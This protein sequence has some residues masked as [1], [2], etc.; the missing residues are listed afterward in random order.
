MIRGIKCGLILAALVV[1]VGGCIDGSDGE[2]ESHADPSEDPQTT[3]YEHIR[4]LLSESCTS[5]HR[6]GGLA[7]FSL[8]SYEQAQRW[9]GPMATAVAARTMP[10]YFADDSGAC[11]S[12]RNSFW[13]SEAQIDVFTAWVDD[14]TPPGDPSIP[15]PP[16][17]EVLA[18]EGPLVTIDTGVDYLPNQSTTDDYRCFV[19]D[20]PGAL[21]ATGFDVA[22]G[23]SRITHHLIAYQVTDE[24][25]AQ[26][27]RKLDTEAEGPGYPC[28]GTGPQVNATTIA[29]W[30]PGAGATIFPEG[31]GVEIDGDLPLI[32]EMHYNIAGGPGETDRTTIIFEKAES[33]SR[34][35][36]YEIGALDYDFSGP[37]GMSSYSTTD[38]TP[39]Q[40]SLYDFGLGDYEGNILLHGAN[41]H[42]HERGLSIKLE[43][44]G[45]TNQCLLDIPHWDFDWQLSYWFEEPIEVRATDSIRI[46]CTWNT[47]GLTEPLVWGD[48]TGDEM[49]LG[50]LY[51]TLVD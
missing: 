6:D 31:T 51:A 2:G 19:I 3:Y 20:S 46:T 1:T 18:L 50:G 43:V 49:C 17:P 29:S 30:A 13:L 38:E 16:E 7:P 28:F 14:D 36:I 25:T 11:G 12:F 41:G 40:W 35:P 47:E 22:P 42:M 8:T 26:A 10:P 37:P 23:N 48:G 9:A 27:A 44:V 15:A 45:N 32:I 5:C 39:L 4:P 24:E 34:T 21:S 33:G